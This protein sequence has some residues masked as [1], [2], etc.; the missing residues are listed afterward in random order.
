MPSNMKNNDNI[1]NTGI[2]RTDTT[3]KLFFFKRKFLL[4]SGFCAL[5]SSATSIGAYSVLND[6]ESAK[7]GLTVGKH[8]QRI[9]EERRTL[10][11][12]TQQASESKADYTQECQKIASEIYSLARRNAYQSPKELID[13]ACK[14]YA[15]KYSDN[16]KI[17]IIIEDLQIIKNFFDGTNKDLMNTICYYHLSPEIPFH[18]RYSTPAQVRDGIYRYELKARR[19]LQEKHDIIVKSM[20]DSTGR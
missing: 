9:Q 18:N 5:A 16:P 19:Y 6:S 3:K 11:D 2:H 10:N 4:L 20:F 8:Y 15:Q 12:I 17:D 1:A 13:F 14:Q 7:I